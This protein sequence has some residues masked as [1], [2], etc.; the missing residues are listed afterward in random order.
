MTGPTASCRVVLPAPYDRDVWLALRNEGVGGSDAATVLGLNPYKS[1]YELW[2]EKRGDLDASMDEPGPDS[3]MWWGH[4][5]EDDVAEAFEYE[6]GLTLRESPGLLAHVDRSWQLASPDR[7]VYD[8]SEL[9]GILEIKTTNLRA[10]PEWE[11]DEIP[12]PALCQTQHYLSVTGLTNA[13]VAALIAGQ[14]FVWKAL[15]PDPDLQALLVEREAEFWQRVV[16]GNAPPPDGSKSAAFALR[17]RYPEA[18]EQDDDGVVLSPTEYDLVKTYRD[19]GHAVKGL[20]RERDSV[21]QQL[22]ERLGT[23]AVAYYDDA[24]VLR[25]SNVTTK[26]LDTT[27]LRKAHPSIAEKFTNESHTRRF[28]ALGGKD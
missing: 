11:A 8:G 20:E 14:T 12:V 13:W 7:F 15:D 27:A 2:M 9:V 16:S 25:W 19:L 1:A 21:A 24:P 6:T 28:T 4:R 10:A 18:D 3:P 23:A 5:L 26:R 22:Q 17:A